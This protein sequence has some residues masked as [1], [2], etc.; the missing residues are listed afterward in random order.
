MFNDGKSH[1]TFT[2]V[3]FRDWKHATG[4]G[5]ML[6]SHDK[7]ST[8][9]AAMVAWSQYTADESKVSKMYISI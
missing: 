1:G 4:K 8:H 2:K 6:T 3:G 5:G 9:L 7:C